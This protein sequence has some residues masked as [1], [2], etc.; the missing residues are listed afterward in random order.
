VDCGKCPWESHE[1]S[2]AVPVCLKAK[3][4]KT[5]EDFR[6]KMDGLKSYVTERV[7]ILH[8]YVKTLMVVVIAVGSRPQS[9]HSLKMQKV[10]RSM[11]AH[12]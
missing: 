2:V 1:C 4:R 12:I 7:C 11:T 3:N 6:K 9:Q 5:A 8:N 10:R